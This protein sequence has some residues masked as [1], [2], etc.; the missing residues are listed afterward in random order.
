[1]VVKLARK[2]TEKKFQETLV[3]HLAQL[4]FNKPSGSMCSC[5]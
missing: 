3:R 4:S 1:M 2:E 5:M